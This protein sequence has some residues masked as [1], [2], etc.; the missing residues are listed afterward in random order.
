M[1]LG[2]LLLGASRNGFNATLRAWGYAQGPGV[3]AIVPC[4]GFLAALY[5]YALTAMGLS[6]LQKV[7]FGRAAFAL[8]VIPLLCC[9]CVGLAMAMAGIGLG[10]LAFLK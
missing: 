7:S 6:E 10:S 8:S 1:H 5:V 3:V 2:A 9:C 4:F